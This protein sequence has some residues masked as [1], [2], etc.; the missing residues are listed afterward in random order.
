MKFGAVYCLY[1]DHEYLDIS[2]ASVKNRFDKVL[3]LISDI[4]WNGQIVDNCFTIMKVKELCENNKNFELVQGHWINETEQRNFGLKKLFDED[5]DYCFVIDSD[6]IYHDF[7]IDK[8]KEFVLQNSNFIAFHIVWN[9]YWKKTYCVISPREDYKPVIVV[10]VDSFQFTANRNGITSIKRVNDFIFTKK[11]EQYNGVLI[12]ENVAF[13]YHLSYARSDEFIKRKLEI[14]SH[15]NEFLPNWYNTVWLGWKSNCINLHPVTPKQYKKAIPENFLSFP[16]QLRQFIKKERRETCSC[17]II[18]V[19]W[20]SYEL[21]FNCIEL[22]KQ[23]TKNYEIIVVD[24]GSR[25]LP[26][27]FK[28]ILKQHGISKCIMNKENLGFTVA[29]NQGIKIA[30]QNSDICLMNVDAEPWLNWLDFLYETLI[31]NSNAGIVGPLGNEIENGYQSENFVKKDTKVFN[32]HFYCV[33][34]SREVI[35]KIGILD[36]R[37]GLGCWEDNDFCIRAMLSGFESWIAAK[38]FVRHKAHQV[39]KINKLDYRELESKNK[40]LLQEKLISTLYRYGSI[41]DLFSLSP[42]IAE[43]CGLVIKEQEN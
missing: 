43:E 10:K 14:S 8:I 32:V 26:I 15:A 1:D 35:K 33:L 24:N 25:K 19:N 30:S 40:D 12:P 20:N 11:Q 2:L 22:I 9:T 41:V 29:V 16:V 21:L 3:F 42:K 7:H 4:P 31:E 39:F 28:D 6:E 13:C 18:L 23:N 36:T 27:E 5:I 37:Y 34:I 38:S 17:S